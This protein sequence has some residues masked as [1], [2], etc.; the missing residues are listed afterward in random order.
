MHRF[1]RYIMFRWEVFIQLVAN[2]YNNQLIRH[3]NINSS[4]SS[5]NNNRIGFKEED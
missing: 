4:S 1:R 5:N 2:L 3:S